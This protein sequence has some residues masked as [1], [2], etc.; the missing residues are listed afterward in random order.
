MGGSTLPVLGAF[1]LLI[2]GGSVNVILAWCTGP[3]SDQFC[4]VSQLA[5]PES[6]V[7]SPHSLVLV[8]MIP[9]TLSGGEHSCGQVR[10]L[11]RAHRCRVS[12]AARHTP[13]AL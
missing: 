7:L 13:H 2:T 3:V 10:H 11:E 12:G 1:F 6:K 9:R 5:Q 8:A 4:L